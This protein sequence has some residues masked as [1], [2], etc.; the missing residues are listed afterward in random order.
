MAP[1]LFVVGNLVVATIAAATIKWLVRT[2][3]KSRSALQSA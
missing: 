3:W 2:A 1:Y